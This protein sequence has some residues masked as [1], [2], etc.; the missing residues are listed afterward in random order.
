MDRKTFIDKFTAQLKEWDAE[1]EKL[2]A[3]A[4]GAGADAKAEIQKKIQ[5]LQDKKKAAQSKLEEAKE[6]SE[7]AWEDLKS[8]AEKAFEDMKG[9]FKNAFSKFKL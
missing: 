1:I 4:Q 9:A 7:E 6:A 8:G 2:E 5:E 3:K